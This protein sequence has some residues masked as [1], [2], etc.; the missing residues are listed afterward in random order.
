[1]KKQTKVII[2]V[3]LLVVIAVVVFFVVNKSKDKPITKSAGAPGGAPTTRS[4]PSQISDCSNWKAKETIKQGLVINPDWIK[5][6]DIDDC[7]ILEWMYHIKKETD[8]GRSYTGEKLFQEA[9][10]QAHQANQ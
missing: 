4:V 10:F 5:R 3:A 6:Y 2:A 8:W 7:T 9:I 1:M